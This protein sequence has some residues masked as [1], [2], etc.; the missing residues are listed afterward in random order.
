MDK[1]KKEIKIEEVEYGLIGSNNI[2]LPSPISKSEQPKN[3]FKEVNEQK[4][5][6]ESV[7]NR[8]DQPVEEKKNTESSFMTNSTIINIEREIRDSPT[9]KWK[10]PDISSL[11]NL[12][13]LKVDQTNAISHTSSALS[14]PDENDRLTENLKQKKQE[15]EELKKQL[16]EKENELRVQIELN[17]TLRLELEQE[18]QLK[19]NSLN[20]NKLE[21]E[22]KELWGIIKQLK[23]EQEQFKNSLLSTFKSLSISSAKSETDQS[24][25][26][27]REGMNRVEETK[28]EKKL[29]SRYNEADYIRQEQVKIDK[30][31]PVSRNKHINVMTQEMLNN[32]AGSG[33][34]QEDYMIQEKNNE[35][36]FDEEIEYDDFEEE[37]NEEGTSGGN[38]KHFIHDMIY[39]RKHDIND[40]NIDIDGR[41]LQGNER[42]GRQKQSK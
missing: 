10:T 39:K 19:S 15:W 11:S 33:S 24:N 37:Y 18:R 30:I 35:D 36:E 40:N 26:I 31:I 20:D 34:N 21:E 3:I 42:R 9:H 2:T 25:F 22:N 17:K 8:Y 14:I 16:E 7:K 13:M 28:Q 1:V 29:E 6:G 27:L 12:N 41:I 38:A 5:K 4:K 23:Q 32:A